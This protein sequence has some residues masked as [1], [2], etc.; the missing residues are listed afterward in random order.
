MTDNEDLQV[1]KEQQ[2][3]YDEDCE[4]DYLKHTNTTADEYNVFY[5]FVSLASVINF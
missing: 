1:L 5:E 4:D 2:N 3:I